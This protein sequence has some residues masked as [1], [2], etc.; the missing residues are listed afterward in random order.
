MS[1]NSQKKT[2]KH[3]RHRRFILSVKTDIEFKDSNKDDIIQLDHLMKSIFMG[4]T[5]KWLKVKDDNT[6]SN[7]KDV[8][9][10][11][12]IGIG[13]DGL[14]LG[15][16]LVHVKFYD[17]LKLNQEFIRKNIKENYPNLN[18]K[19]DIQNLSENDYKQF[20][21]IFKETIYKLYNA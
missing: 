14:A 16:I 13:E 20:L 21:D 6:S 8:N 1:K 5:Y 7:I 12:Y 11:S 18:Y 15:Q 2:Y 10:M 3:L 19:L 9:R 17:K 4:N